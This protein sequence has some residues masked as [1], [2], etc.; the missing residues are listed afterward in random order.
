MKN[1]SFE[2]FAKF[3]DQYEVNRIKYEKIAFAMFA[4]QINRGI[5][6]TKGES[7]FDSNEKIVENISNLLT[8]NKSFRGGLV[9]EEEKNAYCSEVGEKIEGLLNDI[10]R[11]ALIGKDIASL[12]TFNNMP[13]NDR[14]ELDNFVAKY[15]GY[16]Y[17]YLDGTTDFT[18]VLFVTVMVNCM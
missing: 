7:S 16:D 18:S 4:S 8:R 10:E 5:E 15:K 17:S 9:T 2:N 11:I 12:E 14:L 13:S 1:L 6:L 3:S